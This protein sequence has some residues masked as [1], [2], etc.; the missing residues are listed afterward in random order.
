MTSENGLVTTVVVVCM[1]HDKVLKG[2]PRFE[3]VHDGNATTWDLTWEVVLNDMYCSEG[4]ETCEK[5]WVVR[6]TG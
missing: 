6:S 2:R 4:S 1:K 5:D 3:R